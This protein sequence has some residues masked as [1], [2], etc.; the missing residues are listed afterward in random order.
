MKKTLYTRIVAS[1]MLTIFSIGI[2]NAQFAGGTGTKTDPY[3]IATPAQ[4]DSVRNHLAAHFALID[5]LVMTEPTWEPIGTAAAPFT[6]SFDGRGH[7]ISSLKILVTAVDAGLFGVFVPAILG[8]AIQN[9]GLEGAIVTSTAANVGALVGTVDGGTIAFCYSNNGEI[10]GNGTVGG[11][12]GRVRGGTITRSW[13]NGIVLAS[14]NTGGALAGGVLVLSGRGSLVQDCFAAGR[15]QASNI[16]AGL[17][18]MMQT[19]TVNNCYTTAIVVSNGAAAGGIAAN[20]SGNSLISNS[21]VMSDTIRNNHATTLPNR[22]APVNPANSTVRANFALDAIAF[23][24][25]TAEVDPVADSLNGNDGQTRTLAVLQHDTTYVRAPMDWDLEYVWTKEESAFPTLLPPH[26]FSGGTGTKTDPIVITTPEDMA[27]VGSFLNFH[28]ILGNDIDLDGIDFKP[29]GRATR[30]FTGSFNGDGHV[31]SNL[32]IFDTI[33]GTGNF[34]LFGSFAPETRGDAIRNLGLENAKIIVRG[35]P[36]GSLVG[37]VTHGNIFNCYSNNAE[38]YGFGGS[39]FGGLVGRIRGGTLSRS[40]VNCS[41]VSTASTIGALVG[42]VA[43]LS[44]VPGIVENCYALGFV[45][46]TANFASGLAG[47]V[48]AGGRIIN[49]YTAATVVSSGTTATGIAATFAGSATTISEI[50]NCVVLSPTITGSSAATATTLMR[51]AATA[52]NTVRRNNY[53]S[54]TTQLIQLVDV[55]TI[56]ADSLNG[57]NGLTRPDADFSLATTYTTAPMN[58]NFTDIWK[59]DLDKHRF[60][61]FGNVP[62]V[63]SVAFSEKE[64]EIMLSFTDTLGWTVLPLAADQTVTFASLDETIASVT[65]EGIVTGLKVGETKIVI[66]AGTHTDTVSVTIA[67]PFVTSVTFEVPQVLLEVDSTLTP[68]WTVLPEAADQTVAF[69]SLDPTI[70]TVSATGVI[71]GVAAGIT[72]IVVSAQGDE[73]THT[74]TITVYV[75]SVAVENVAFSVPETAI[76]LGYSHQLTWEVLPT[77]AD[78]KFVTLRNLD[79]NIVTVNA[80]GMAEGRSVGVGRVV[81]YAG[82]AAILDTNITD[83]IVITVYADT[84]FA[85]AGTKAD[86]FIITTPQEFDHARHFLGNHFRV[87]NDLDMSSIEN[88][89]PI[90]HWQALSGADTIRNRPFTGSF[91]G[92]GF[93]ISNLTM[94]DTL[95]SNRGLFS[96]FR[97]AVEG[98]AIENIVIRNSTFTVGSTSGSIVGMLFNGTVQN[99]AVHARVRG[100]PY[101]SAGSIAGIVGTARGGSV[102]QRCWFS[103][104]VTSSGNTAAGIVAGLNDSVLVTDNYSTGHV[105]AFAAPNA[106]AASY[107]AGIS[108]TLNNNSIVQNNYSTASIEA[109]DNVAGI[110]TAINNGGNPT[111]NKPL[112]QNNVAVNRRITARNASATNVH[113]VIS[114]SQPAAQADSNVIRNNY[115]LSTMEVY[116]GTT[117]KTE[118]TDRFDGVNRTMAQLQLQTTYALPPLLWDFTNVWV[119]ATEGDRLPIFRWLSQG[120]SSI[121]DWLQNPT[122]SNVEI[123]VYPNPTRGDVTVKVEDANIKQI[124]IYSMNGQLVFSTTRPEFNIENLQPALYLVHAITDKGNFVSRIM[125]W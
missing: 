33:T 6:G 57:A 11:L 45:R 73:V 65:G 70:A 62:A 81:V 22:I 95:N 123:L 90:G 30:P 32:T 67:F 119:M 40:W 107:A 52:N 106:T 85:G 110:S 118:F 60:P 49:S 42:A 10:T 76:K 125:K 9:L 77:N 46:T 87:A 122:L 91:D 13:A 3:Q 113:R 31:I 94:F 112:H 59:I 17:I 25:Q 120:S 72:G 24:R 61:I 74:D 1:V 38:I 21:M 99:V 121:Q 4:L 7:V 36:V 15:I 80:E 103:D 79:T 75:F 104:T 116:V 23:I 93:T 69:S 86:P 83:T 20:I 29:I 101:G 2:A 26:I 54:D 64:I 66:S 117:Q 108:A 47:S 37:D 44:G 50:T 105:A 114:T 16:A 8:D 55:M 102:I 78:H 100:N 19:A 5:D 14:G 111:N 84:I 53:A 48:T 51:I 63:T 34:G 109:L 58:W 88:F 89:L 41:L 35:T 18:G 96:A 68:K 56:A 97:P 43:A 98:D 27:R 12:V 92:G 115:A 39:T 124:R 71:R 82:Y 28:Y